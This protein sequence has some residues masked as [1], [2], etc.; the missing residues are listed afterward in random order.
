MAQGG[1]PIE[2]SGTL[3]PVELPEHAERYQKLVV[4]EISA[5]EEGHLSDARHANVASWISVCPSWV[6]ARTSR[7]R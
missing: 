7:W 2:H 3:T 5:F 6:C 4:R 1:L